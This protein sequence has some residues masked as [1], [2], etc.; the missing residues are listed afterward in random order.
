[1]R[2]IIAAALA[3]AALAGCASNE[4]KKAEADATAA[5][6]NARVAEAQA[7]AEEAKAVQALAAKVDAGGAS[8]YLVAKALNGLGARQPAPVQVVQ[9][10]QSIVGAAWQALLQIADLG[11]RG[12]GIK[13]NRDVAIIQSNNNRDVS[14]STNSTFGALGQSIA[15]AGTAGYP[16]VQAPGAVTTNTLSGTGVLGSGTYTAPVT[17]TTTTTTTHTCQG[18]T[19]ANGGAGGTGTTTGGAGAAGGGAPGGNC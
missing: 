4:S 18:G 14:L 15:T 11:L 3:V 9:Q 19:A 13:A 12:W 7:V 5:L 17:T 6:A 1:M 2:L 8:A 16:Y 10:P